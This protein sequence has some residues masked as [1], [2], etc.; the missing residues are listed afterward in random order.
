M[1]TI[2]KTSIALVL[3]V[4]FGASMTLL[5]MKLLFMDIPKS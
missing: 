4:F 1:T 5:N 2:G 3:A